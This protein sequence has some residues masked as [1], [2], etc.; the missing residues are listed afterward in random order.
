MKPE[1]LTEIISGGEDLTVE[2]NQSRN[3][4][5]PDVFETVCAF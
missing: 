3:K 4:L 1:K 2:F 5:N